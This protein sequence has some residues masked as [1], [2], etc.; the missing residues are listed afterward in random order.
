MLDLRDE[1]HYQPELVDRLNRLHAVISQ[2]RYT[3]ASLM[4]LAGGLFLMQWALLAD[5]AAGYP[6]LGIPVL[7]AAV[8]L[9]ITPAENV[10]KWL[11]WSV[12]L[13][14]GFLSFRDLNWIQAMTKRH[15]SLKSRA[16]AYLLSST[17]VPVDALRHFWTQLVREEEKGQTGN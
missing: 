5:Q 6:L 4:A 3:Y 10:A 9:S 7:V 12:R 16:E 2:H 14:T 11:S 15:P 17:P 1:F 13:S 8:W